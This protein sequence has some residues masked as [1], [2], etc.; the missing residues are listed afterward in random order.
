MKSK[1]SV[2]LCVLLLLALSV[3]S[4]F[5]YAFLGYSEIAVKLEANASISGKQYATLNTIKLPLKSF[6]RNDNEVWYNGHLYDIASYAVVHDSV[7]ISVLRD[8]KEEGLVNIISEYFSSHSDCYSSYA[9][10]HISSR[11]TFSP[12]DIKCL[13]ERI[14][15]PFIDNGLSTPPTTNITENPVFRFETV[16]SPPPRA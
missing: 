5:Y 4:F 7:L 12:N 13:C 11:H 9:G 14:T 6:N 3:G 1:L 15:I 2:F 16:D 10:D 8:D